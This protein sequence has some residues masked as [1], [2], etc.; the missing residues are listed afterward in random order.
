M[1][2]NTGTTPNGPVPAAE[3]PK[4]HPEAK[5]AKKPKAKSEKKASPFKVGESGHLSKDQR[6]H[7]VLVTD[8]AD[9]LYNPKVKEPPPEK[10][11]HVLADKRVGWLETNPLTILP[12]GRIWSGRTKWRVLEKAERERGSEIPVPYKVIDIDEMDAADATDMLDMQVQ[13]L[14]PM[15]VA[16]K[17]LRSLSRGKTEKEI[18]DTTGISV[19]D[20]HGYLLLMDEDKCPPSMQELIREGFLSKSAALELARKSATM[21]KSEL[22]A[23]AEQIAKVAAGGIRVT[24][25]RVKSATGD[26]KVATKKEVKQWLLDIQSDLPTGKHGEFVGLACIVGLEVAIGTRSIASAKGLLK[27]LGKGE[28]VKINF[29][30]YASAADAPDKPVKGQ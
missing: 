17:V 10:L 26:E 4:K 19:E 1:S 12:D 28:A 27:K 18:M 6:K 16:E 3:E 15:L 7:I 24:T 8:E 11:H 21:S 9:P 23:A 22:V 29:K 13:K 5:P 2:E 14:N 30:Q 20:Q 25:E